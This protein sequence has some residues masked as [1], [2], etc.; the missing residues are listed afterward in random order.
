[1]NG[2]RRACLTGVPFLLLAGCLEAGDTIRIDLFVTAKT[3][4]KDV[5]VLIGQE[6]Y[7]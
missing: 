1:M 7:L 2:Q 6:K 3:P 5:W 4:L